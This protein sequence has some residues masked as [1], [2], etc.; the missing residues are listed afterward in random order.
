[1][2]VYPS[3]GWRHGSM[4]DLPWGIPIENPEFRYHPV[5]VYTL[6]VTLPI[7]IWLWKKS[8]QKF[9]TGVPISYVLLFYGMG[10]ML[11]SFFKMKVNVL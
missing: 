5:N 9:G 6:L 2:L 1:M 11:V 4:T 7:W 3:L 8:P 10:L